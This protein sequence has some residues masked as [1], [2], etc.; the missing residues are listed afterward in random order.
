MNKKKLALTMAVAAT[1][2]VSSVS[3]SLPTVVYAQEIANAIEN[4]EKTVENDLEEPILPEED[5]IEGEI[6]LPEENIPA[7]VEILSIK[8]L[9][10]ETA[11]E[12]W[13]NC[14]KCTQN[15]PHMISTGGDL[16][17]IRTHTTTDESGNTIINGYFKLVN[18]IVFTEEDFQEGGNFYNDGQTWIPIGHLN[19]QGEAGVGPS[20]CG[21]FDG[22]GFSIKNLKMTAIDSDKRN[23]RY[24]GVLMQLGENGVITNTVFDGIENSLKHGPTFVVGRMVSDTSELSNIVIKNSKITSP[25][26][27]NVMFYSFLSTALSG[28]VSNISIKNC[29]A[30]PNLS[31]WYGGIISGQVANAKISNLTIDNCSYPIYAYSGMLFGNI[32]GDNVVENLNINNVD[33][34]IRH[35]NVTVISYDMFP[36]NTRKLTLKHSNINVNVKQTQALPLRDFIIPEGLELE[37][38]NLKYNLNLSGNNSTVKAWWKIINDDKNGVAEGKGSANFSCIDS[39]GN[40]AEVI[41]YNNSYYIVGGELVDDFISPNYLVGHLNEGTLPKNVMPESDKLIT[42]IRNGYAFKGWFD[43]KL[44]AGNPI[45]IFEKNKLYYVK[46]EEKKETIVSF[47]DKF[48]LDK[49]YNGKAVS[50]SENDYAVTDGAGDVTFSYQE[51]KGDTWGDMNDVP[52][53]AGIY[54][55]KAVVA[56]NDTHKSAETA[57]KEFTIHKAKPSYTLPN[58]LVI[59]KGK[60][61]AAV[62]LPKGFTWADKTQTA[63]K[64]GT[65]KFKAT[66]TPDD[67]VNYETVEVMIPVE[68]VPNIS[69]INHAP[70]IEVCDKTLTVGDVF[71]PLNDVIATDKED[72]MLTDKI[73]VWSN[74]VNINKAG[75]YEVTYKVTDSKGASTTKTIMVTVKEK[76]VDTPTIPDDI[77]KPDTIKPDN[78]TEPGSITKPDNAMKPNETDTPKT[79]DMTNIGIVALMFTMS[80]LGI[81]ILAVLKKKRT[82]S[83]K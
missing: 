19:L 37:Y 34:I 40:E 47:K 3:G 29:T 23:R 8:E 16:D 49:D 77:T 75:I 71:D 66:Y 52:T 58:D 65:Q 55:V 14:D 51:K 41:T 6:P 61:L 43:N 50:I 82:L 31:D 48:K 35:P 18:D 59:G 39:N 36:V 56:E 38:D 30:N 42:P 21:V 68:V 13:E 1:I 60:T 64:I 62:K 46:W 27:S 7:D 83:N 81:A 73:Q 67:T 2:T 5:S 4:E 45:E 10:E 78:T 57:W 24:T 12:S 28:T 9:D 20:F 53:N 74:S 54:R 69:S 44:L 63:D 70:E 80:T 76:N 15:K 22:S 79:G 17:K 72:G 26:N 11:E 33:A 25:E 32:Y